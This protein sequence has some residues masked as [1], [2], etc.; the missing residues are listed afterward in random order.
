MKPL[1]LYLSQG[2][3]SMAAHI[4]LRE[5]GAEFSAVHIALREGEQH[6]KSYRKVNSH[7]KVPA[8][9]IGDQVLTE[10]VAVL[11]W[12]ARSFPEAGLISA[13]TPEDEAQVISYLAWLTSEV[14]P[15]FGP[16]FH[17]ESFADGKEAQRSVTNHARERVAQHFAEINDRLSSREWLFDTFG[18]ADGYLFAFAFWAHKVFRMKIANTH[19]N[20]HAHYERMLARPSV[21]WVLE[22]EAGLAAAA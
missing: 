13:T 15:A 1:T 12:I 18:V 22:R 16:L 4:A 19:P 10:N 5:A 9:R 14:H 2:A 6:S 8:L 11:H 20:L 17:P 21:Q 3:C 7:E